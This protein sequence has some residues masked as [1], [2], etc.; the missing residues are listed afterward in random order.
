MQV[1]PS[2]QRENSA[3]SCSSPW[4]GIAWLGSSPGSCGCQAGLSSGPGAGQ[5]GGVGSRAG[6]WPSLESPVC[7]TL[8]CW[9]AQSWRLFA[10]TCGLCWLDVI[11]SN[12]LCPLKCRFFGFL[13]KH[14][15]SGEIVFVAF[16]VTWPAPIVKAHFFLAFWIASFPYLPREPIVVQWCGMTAVLLGPSRDLM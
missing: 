5:A 10:V 2:Q 1:V 14:L 15:I 8:L 12:E 7:H 6:T 3:R 13:M 9:A 4:A 16:V 11:K